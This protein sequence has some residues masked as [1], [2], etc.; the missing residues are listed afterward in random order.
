LPS[1]LCSPGEVFLYLLRVLC[2]TDNLRVLCNTDVTRI[3]PR[4]SNLEV[5]V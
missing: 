4:Q 5:L 3:P 2:Y 1:L